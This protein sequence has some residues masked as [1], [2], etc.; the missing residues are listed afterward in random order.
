MYGVAIHGGAGLSTPENLGAE[1]ERIARVDL[2]RSIMAANEILK[3]GGSA[4]EAA[5]VAVSIMEDSPVFNAGKGSVFAADGVQR[6]DASI[7]RGSDM[8]A[9][10]LCGVSRIRNPIRAAA[11]VMNHTPHVMLYGRD[12]EALAEEVGLEFQDHAYFHTDYRWEQLQRAKKAKKIILDHEGVEQGIS[13]GTVGA[14]TL[15]QHGN[16]VAATSTGGLVNKRA[17]RIGDSAIMGAVTYAKNSTCAISATGHGELFIRA[18]IAG[19]MSHWMEFGN[20]SMRDA[21]DQIIFSELPDD[22]GGLIAIDQSGEIYMPFNT[23]GMFRAASR[24]G[25]PPR[26]EVWRDDIERQGIE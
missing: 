2:R 12:A 10:A 11:A 25:E 19:R 13:K 24:N 7:M 18:N 3:R 6:M 22:T 5:I 23:G 20:V 17:S 8:K 21:A 26:V 16:V 1:R 14:V 4:E 9:G 15:D